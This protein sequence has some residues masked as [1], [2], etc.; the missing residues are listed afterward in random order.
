M[1]SLQSEKCH[2]HMRNLQAEQFVFPT[3]TFKDSKVPFEWNLLD[4]DTRNSV[5]IGEFKCKMLVQIRP[6]CTSVYN[7]DNIT[8]IRNLTRLR[9]DLVLLMSIDLDITL[10]KSVVCVRYWK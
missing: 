5:S 1:K 3:H 4:E 10:F 2:V 8:G 9:L 6:P 7:V